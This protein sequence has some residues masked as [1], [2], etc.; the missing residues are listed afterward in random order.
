M[1]YDL[2]TISTWMSIRTS[3][4]AEP[5]IWKPRSWKV[6]ALDVRVSTAEDGQEFAYLVESGMPRLLDMEDLKSEMYAHD[7]QKVDVGDPESVMAFC[8]RFGIVTSPLYDG[9]QRLAQFRLR[10]F[11]RSRPKFV[12]YS[13]QAVVDYGVYPFAIGIREFDAVTGRRLR[14]REDEWL[15]PAILSERARYLERKDKNVVGAISIA[16]VGQAIRL[17]QTSTILSSA[18]NYAAETQMTANMLADY[19]RNP[20]YLSQTG[21]PYFL[22]TDDPIYAGHRV[23]TFER[24]LAFDGIK[25]EVERASGEG[26]NPKA[27]FDTTLR[28]IYWR[29]A[30]SAVNFLAA[31]ARSYSKPPQFEYGA[32]YPK[33]SFMERMSSIVSG[34]ERYET[35]LM[36]ELGQGCIALAIIAQFMVSHSDRHGYKRCENCGRIFKKSYEAAWVKN[37]RDSRFCRRSCNVA[38]NKRK[39]REKNG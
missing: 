6:Y 15:D 26:M 33:V 37:I 13:S 5:K 11:T 27:A 18:F 34:S 25:E 14:G 7:L 3:P 10:F 32:D 16:E 12:A 28:D 39:A 35:A 36:E 24:M 29:N 30:D 4:M 20:R 2:S 38:V 1:N 23:D 22:V 8:N 21:A 9:R 31:A 17:L 19:L